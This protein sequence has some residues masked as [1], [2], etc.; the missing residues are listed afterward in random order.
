MQALKKVV[1][2]IPVYKKN[3]ENAFF[4]NCTKILNNYDFC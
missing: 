1:V 3:P 2:V 4:A